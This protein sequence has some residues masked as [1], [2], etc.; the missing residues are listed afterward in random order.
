LPQY[1]RRQFFGDLTGGVTVAVMLVPQAMAYALLAG[2]PA[3]YGLYASL[4]PL[5]VYPIAATSR[6]IALGVTA[7]DMIVVAAGVSLVATPGTPEYIGLVVILSLMVGTI[8]IVFGALRLGFIVNLLSTPVVTGFMTAAA[9]FIAVSQI[10]TFVGAS[11]H[12]EGS[13]F[14][15][16]ATAV[17]HALPDGRIL[18]SAVGFCSLVVL[19]LLKTWS[20]RI[21][22]ALIVVAVA[23]IL[24]WKFGWRASGLSTVG[25]VPSGLPAFAF[26]DVSAGALTRLLPTAFTLALIQIMTIIS[27]ARTYSGRHG[28]PI[29]ANRELISLGAANISAGFFKAPPVS[30]SLSRTAVGEQAG[31]QTPMANIIAAGVVLLTL[32]FVTPAFFHLPMP[33]LSAVII[34]ASLSL[35]SVADWKRIIRIKAIDGLLAGVT[36]AAT[37]VVGLRE[38]LLIGV[39]AS[40]IAIMY[41]ISKPNVA[42]LGRLPGTRSFRSLQRHPEAE[43]HEEVLIIRIDASFSFANADFLRDLLLDG[44]G[45][46]GVE[47]QAIIIDASSVNDLDTTAVGVLQFVA[48]T[49]KTRD[50]ELLL[51]GV[52]GPVEDT[53]RLSG[54]Y[55]HLGADHFFLSPHRALDW[56]QAR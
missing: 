3:V 1:T 5:V 36:L 49:L 18:A 30:G 46:V 20:N 31:V 32:L 16:L 10:G 38:G 19:L 42:I 15:A 17:A 23:T 22:A 41:R 2:L 11:M 28:Y 37:L 54:L 9:L 13:S 48:D 34:V 44:D 12:L 43:E 6:H 7:I 52:K 14:I 39:V 24:T 40:V 27:L 33:A 8:Q 35:I 29:R 4:V 25:D 47:T 50:I 26:P 53:L 51:A 56:F 21:P 45:P 55:D